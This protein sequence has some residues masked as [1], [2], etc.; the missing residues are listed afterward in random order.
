MLIHSDKKLNC[1]LISK[2]MKC[3]LFGNKIK[4]G[5]VQDDGQLELTLST[6]ESCSTL[7]ISLPC[8]VKCINGI[9]HFKKC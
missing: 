9:A 7:A 3:N 6:P 4:F 2:S 5:L 8:T 1:L